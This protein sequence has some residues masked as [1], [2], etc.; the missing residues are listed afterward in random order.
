[1][2]KL[3]MSTKGSVHPDGHPA[4]VLIYDELLNY[5]LLVQSAE[6]VCRCGV[7]LGGLV[8]QR[9]YQPRVVL[10]FDGP[11]DRHLLRVVMF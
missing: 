1:M 7:H 4:I 3:L 2:T 6:R 11:R 9:G 5:Y 8:G 10:Q